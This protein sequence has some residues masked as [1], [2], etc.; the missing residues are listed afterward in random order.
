M[1]DP[2]EPLPSSFRDPHGFVFRS[3]GV[4]LR[5]VNE[6]HRADYDA[7]RKTG[8]YD[9]LVNDGLLVSHQE[10]DLSRAARP[11]AYRVLEPEV[12]PFV[13]Y[14]YEWSFSAFK[15]AAMTTLRAQDAALRRG[16]SMRDASSFNVQFNGSQPVLIDTLSFELLREGRPWV[17][18]RQFCE[19]FLA[20]LALMSMRDVRLGRA[21]TAF[22]D[23][24]PLDLAS[25]LLPTR[26]K[27]RSGLQMHI[28]MHARSQRR[29]SGDVEGPPRAFSRR[30]FEG[31][32][33]SLMK[34]IEALPSPTRGSHWDHYYEEADHYVPEAA[35]RKD[36]VV[37][38]WIRD[39]EPATLWDLGA[40]TG[41]YAK[42]AAA[43]TITVAFDQDPVVVERMYVEGRERADD[44]ILPLVMD[45]TNPSPALGWAHAERMSLQQR[46]PADLLLALALVHH[47][48]IGGNVPLKRIVDLLAEL[49]RSVILEWIPIDDPKVVSMLRSR[50]N[51]FDAYDERSLLDEVDR[52]F[53]VRA[54][55]PLPSSGRVLFQLV[56][57]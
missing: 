44:P 37:G 28:A 51:I 1:I 39:A 40:N 11:G 19:H 43:R 16:M 4:L 20:P 23:G 41:R 36:A 9:E 47:L 49:G 21:L 32:I 13:S 24:V 55:E 27:L 17:A 42:M 26:A 7:M 10:A 35:Q 31:L 54:R 15:D 12:V 6:A 46:G 33:A 18:Y 45:L 52:R 25:E 53:V 56:Q 3:Q 48:A 34:A 30:A 29:R 50:E 57:R 8:L 2:P 5:Q 22:L 14:P 38:A